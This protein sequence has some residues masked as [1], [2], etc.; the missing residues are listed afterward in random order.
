DNRHA[1]RQT[2]QMKGLIG[3]DD[4]LLP[5]QMVGNEGPGTG[6]QQNNSRAYLIAVGE[7]YGI[8]V[9]QHRPL[10]NDFD[11]DGFERPDIG[12]AQP[13]DLKVLVGDERGP[14]ET[15]ALAGPAVTDG[16]FE[17]FGET[18][19]VDEQFLR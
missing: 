1:A 13:L 10:A 18:A 16:V 19:G 8:G 4:E 5:R 7:A 12:L 15:H 17:V 3:S 9:F 14:V 11:T 2:L 6:G